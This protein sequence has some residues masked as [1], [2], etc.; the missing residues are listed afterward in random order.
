M[1]T[2]SNYSGLATTV[3]DFTTE[4]APL[5]MGLIGLVG[6]SAGLIIVSAIRHYLSQQKLQPIPQA[7]LTAPDHQKVA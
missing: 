6:V 1:W 5:L 2:L 7:N 3:V 4:F